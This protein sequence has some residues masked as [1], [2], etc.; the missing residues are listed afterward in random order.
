MLA[1]QAPVHRGRECPHCDHVI[2]PDEDPNEHVVL[3]HRDRLLATEAYDAALAGGDSVEGAQAAYNRVL[4][5]YAPGPGR[6]LRAA[7]PARNRL[8]LSPA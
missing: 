2:R 7:T 4:R 1:Y 3:F 6:Y 5:Q 8:A